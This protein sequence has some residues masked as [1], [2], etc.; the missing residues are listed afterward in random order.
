MSAA[1][2]ARRYQ[3]L[4]VAEAF[5]CG[6]LFTAGDEFPLDPPPR[7]VRDCIRDLADYQ[8]TRERKAS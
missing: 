2:E 5:L 3:E 7:Q 4:L 1:E 8:P 6:E